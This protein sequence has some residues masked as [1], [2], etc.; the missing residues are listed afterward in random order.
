MFGLILVAIGLGVTGAFLGTGL[1]VLGMA[2]ALAI[3]LRQELQRT[4]DWRRPRTCIASATSWG[5]RGSR[6][7]AWPCS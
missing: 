1:S 3:P 5:A 7:P 4:A 2:F 6:S